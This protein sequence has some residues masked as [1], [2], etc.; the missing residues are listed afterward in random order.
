MKQKAII[1]SKYE[2][3]S[4]SEVIASS[5]QPDNLDSPEN[6]EIKTSRDG[7]EVKSEIIVEGEIKTL[8]NT[9]EDLLACTSTAEKMI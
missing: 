7:K 8:L 6:V 5:I 2:D 4:I 3:E 1:V 9:L